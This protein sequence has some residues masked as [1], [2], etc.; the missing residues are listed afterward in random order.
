[1]DFRKTFSSQTNYDNN[2]IFRRKTSGGQIKYLPVGQYAEPF[3]KLLQTIAFISLGIIIIGVQVRT[4]KFGSPA[5]VIINTSCHNFAVAVST[6][7]DMTAISSTRIRHVTVSMV[8]L[9]RT[10]YNNVI[11]PNEV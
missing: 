10:R 9:P 6:R 1:M 4:P 5:V 7:I 2:I 8:R 3:M 11:I